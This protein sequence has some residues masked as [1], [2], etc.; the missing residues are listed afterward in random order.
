MPTI[1]PI[2]LAINTIMFIFLTILPK[3]CLIS[4]FALA[5]YDVMFWR[6]SFRRLDLMLTVVAAA[7]A[8]A[9]FNTDSN[10]I[11][12]ASVKLLLLIMTT[13][14]ISVVLY[15]TAKLQGEISPQWKMGLQLTFWALLVDFKPFSEFISSSS[16]E[17]GAIYEIEPNYCHFKSLV[18]ARALMSDENDLCLLV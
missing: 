13:I 8:A 15:C 6:H 17:V 14:K 10:A 11:C 2:Q 5:R 9:T 18:D 3:L 12:Y 16:Q 1:S 7:A 4:M